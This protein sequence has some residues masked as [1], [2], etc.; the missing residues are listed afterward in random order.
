VMPLQ[1]AYVTNTIVNSS[2]FHAYPQLLLHVSLNIHVLTSV[3]CQPEI[4][5]SSAQGLLDIDAQATIAG[6]VN[7]DTTFSAR[8]DVAQ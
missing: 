5:P 8:G 1:H 7:P 3:S 4:T 6:R 2:A